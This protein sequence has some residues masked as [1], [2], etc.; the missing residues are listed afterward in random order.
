MAFQYLHDEI[1]N[2]LFVFSDEDSFVAA[3]DL[4]RCDWRRQNGGLVLGDWP[5]PSRQNQLEQR[6][7]SI[8]TVAKGSTCP[9]IVTRFFTAM[10]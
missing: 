6:L 10:D 1:S 4:L 9:D 8:L 7:S 2:V 3:L 5:H